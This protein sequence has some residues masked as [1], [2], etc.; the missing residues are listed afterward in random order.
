MPRTSISWG[1]GLSIALR[2]LPSL[3][4]P[5]ALAASLPSILARVLSSESSPR[6][7]RA[8]LDLPAPVQAIISLVLYVVCRSAVR[9]FHRYIDRKRLGPDVI[10]VPR[11][12]G[13]WLWNLDLIPAVIK[14]REVGKFGYFHRLFTTCKRTFGRLLCG[15]LG[16][17]YR[18]IWQ[19]V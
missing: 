15:I 3:V 11:V 8:F 17:T 16:T 9:D 1:A 12:K 18:R 14:S 5:P 19:Y 10:E 4:L 13:N 2:S 6:F 7:S